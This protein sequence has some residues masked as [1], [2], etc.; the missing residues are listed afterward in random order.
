M[1]ELPEPPRGIVR[2]KY[3]TTTEGWN[4]R[5]MREGVPFS[6]MFAD[7]KY[8]SPE[9]ALAAAIEWRNQAEELLP[10][11]DRREYAN[12]GHRN[13]QSG[14]TGVYRTP[15]HYRV[16]GTPVYYWTASWCPQPGKRKH[17]SFSVDKYGEDEA[18]RLAIKAR[19]E[20]IAH[21]DPV[22]PEGSFER[23]RRDQ[24]EHDFSRDIF[25]FEG[26]EKFRIHR[27]KERDPAI[28]QEKIN[29]F[30]ECTVICFARSANSPLRSSTER[31][32]AA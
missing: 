9:G 19:E 22:W 25:A 31:S 24:L 28:R 5:Y 23:K 2:L 21:L 10:P 20:A 4:A 30:L 6:Q 27:T 32:G 8:G 18:K 17:R 1:S 11:R 7:S 16:D 26:E 12:I 3:K 14:H 29:A 13:N 15:Q